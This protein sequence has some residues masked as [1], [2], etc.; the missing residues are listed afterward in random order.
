MEANERKTC[1]DRAKRYHDGIKQILLKQWDPIGVANEPK[2]HDEYDHY[3]GEIYGLLIRR[4][5]KEKLAEHLWWIETEHMG[6]L[7]NRQHT[8]EVAD[9]LI[10]LRDDLQL[11]PE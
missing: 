2:A 11:S 4:V 3:V 10:G 7:G 8:E 9:L 5:P 1:L 6:L